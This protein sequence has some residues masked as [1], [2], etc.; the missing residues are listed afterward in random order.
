MFSQEEVNAA[1]KMYHQCGSVTKNIRI[2][3]Y[4]T[5]R[6]LYWWI[7]NEGKEK[8]PRKEMNTTNTEERPPKPFNQFKNGCDSSLL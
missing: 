3:G 7:E 2:M 6:A 1:L 4:P 8:P 5:R